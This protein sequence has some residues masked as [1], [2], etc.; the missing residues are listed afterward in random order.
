MV[1][2]MDLLIMFYGTSTIFFDTFS[3]RGMDFWLIFALITLVFALVIGGLAAFMTAIAI[4]FNNDAISGFFSGGVVVIFAFFG[5][6]L[7]TI[8]LFSPLMHELGNWTPNGAI[9]T[10]YLQLMQGFS[11]RDFPSKLYRV[12]LMSVLF[13]ILS[14]ALFPKRRLM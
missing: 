6:S 14:R 10:A 3:N 12:M 5:G 2:T 4:Q 8:E 1:L 7:T 9:M 11:L 13:I